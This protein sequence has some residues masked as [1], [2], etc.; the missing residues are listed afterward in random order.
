MTQLNEKK[1]YLSVKVPL[2]KLD[3]AEEESVPQSLSGVIDTHIH[4]FPDPFFSAVWKWFDRYGWSIRY[5]F[6]TNQI[7][8]FLFSRGIDHLVLFQYAH[9]PGISSYLNDYMLE[10]IQEFNNI[11]QFKG[12]ITGLATVFPGENN[13]LDIL[14]T[15]FQKGL[16][17]VKLHAHVQCFDLLSQDM[18]DIYNLCTKYKLPLVIHAGREPG[19]PAYSCDPYQLCGAYKTESVLKSY[20][21]L[22]LCIPH[23]GMD[24]FDEYKSMIERY[25]NLWLDTAMAI[26]DYLPIDNIPKIDLM[27]SDR[28]MYGSDFPNIPYAW[29]RELKAL[30]ALNLSNDKI[31][32]ICQE[33]AKNFFSIKS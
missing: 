15:A 14:E 19:S 1:S 11:E 12:R 31:K 6:T 7:V 25:D 29:D 18:A 27:R 33:N 8:N 17:G 10:K 24:E 5:K 20:P 9:K 28:I 21:M 4:I 13:A 23:L 26:T 32:R 2:P 22:K 16:K 3:D 30:A